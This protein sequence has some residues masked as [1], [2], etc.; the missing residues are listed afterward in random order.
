MSKF[1]DFRSDSS[2]SELPDVPSY[3][4]MSLFDRIHAKTAST[5]V[6]ELHQTYASVLSEP[7][8]GPV[9]A[10]LEEEPQD[11]KK[12]RARKS[13]VYFRCTKNIKC[14]SLFLLKM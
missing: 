4:K 3:S 7:R 1:T 5:R 13:K 9:S 8:G 12:K 10:S 2:D 14:N 6:P 11:A